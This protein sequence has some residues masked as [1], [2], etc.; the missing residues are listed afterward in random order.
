M[1]HL[2]GL[3]FIIIV[4][5]A[6]GV[7]GMGWWYSRRQ[8]STEEYFVAGR[9]VNSFIIG[10]SVIASLLS[11]VTYLSTPGE[12]IKNGP[13][14]M[15]S[16]IH[17]PVSFLIV[18]YLVIPRIMAQPITT[19]YELLEKNFGTGIRQ[20]ASVMFILSRIFWMGLVIY[21]C[22]F[23]VSTVSG[24]ELRYVLVGVGVVGTLYTALGGIRAVMMTDMIQFFILFGGAWLTIIVITV[25]CGGVSGWWPDW[26]SQALQDL[27]WREVKL[28]SV[29][30]FDRLTAFSI[31]VYSSAF[32]I[33]T[34]TCDQ[35]VIQ[36][37]LCT[38]DARAARRGFGV[39][40]C[41]DV[42]T[43]ITMSLTGLALLGFFL[44]FPEILP[45]TTQLASDQA[46]KLFPYFI[47]HVLPVGVSGLVISALFAAAMSSLDSGISSIG[48]VLMHDFSAV[49]AQGCDN[50]AERL[51]RAKRIS[52]GIGA[53]AI[54]LSSV[55]V[56]IP[57]QNFLEV[58]VRIGSLFVPP[59][60][61]VFALAF[62]WKRSTPA[63]A[64]TAVCV[65]LTSSL[66]MTYWQQILTLLFGSAPDFS[67]VLIMPVA[68]LF[69]FIAG[70]LVSGFTKPRIAAGA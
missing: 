57:G 26:S 18:G 45:D 61:V 65:S 9:G 12:M 64:R 54:L 42:V 10:I 11:S 5:Y 20:T 48:T 69:G 2:R 38:R 62:F 56:L 4:L 52:L 44:R 68:S 70:V 55:M 66:T 51:R 59:L 60:F 50:D 24:I 46:D 49:F 1:G 37:F 3:D 32:W 47:G 40:V 8:S 35:V 22:S 15:W 13:G 34:A 39:S 19:G 58:A 63:G 25:Q 21:T 14:W 53:V 43:N 41:G 29:N 16:M 28:F 67:I 33:C 17:A 31:F 7:L 23:A 27:Q 6:L 36:R 30:P